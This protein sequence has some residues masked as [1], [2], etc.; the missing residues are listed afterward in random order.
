[1]PVRSLDELRRHQTAMLDAYRELMRPA[2]T[3]QASYAP[4]SAA[5]HFGQVD[6]VVSSDPTHGP[7]LVIQ[8]IV[9][10]GS[11]PAP[12]HAPL[13]T[14][15]CYPAPGLAVAAYGPGDYVSITVAAGAVIAERLA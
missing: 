8:P 10:S 14:L 5:V 15:R 7:H 6:S 3:V 9:F 12:T 2:Q 1:M 13:A 4:V 11:P